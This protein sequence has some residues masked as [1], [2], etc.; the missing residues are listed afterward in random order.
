MTTRV[1]FT[2]W[3]AGLDAA[4][5]T[6]E[7]AGIAGHRS[8]ARGQEGVLRVAAADADRA[9][10]LLAAHDDGRVVS[11]ADAAW[12]QCYACGADLSGGEFHCPACQAVV[13]DPHGR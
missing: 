8:S 7:A 1:V 9:R 3:R 11:A 4:L 12:F 6:L 10:Q 5:K 2:A 13:G